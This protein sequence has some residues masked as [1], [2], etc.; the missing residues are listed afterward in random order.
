QYLLNAIAHRSHGDERKEVVVDAAGYRE[1]RRATLESLALRVAQQVRTSGEQ[2]ELDP[3]TAVER[4]VVHL[5]LKDVDGVATT[6]EGTE[7]NRYVVVLPGWLAR[8][9]RRDTGPDGASRS[10]GRAGDAARRRAACGRRGARV[11]RDGGRRR[12]R[13]RLAGDPARGRAPRA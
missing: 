4:K 8:R 13:G 6:S 3:M 9:G 5:Q 10:C 2:V 1:R 7:P 12:E 11:R